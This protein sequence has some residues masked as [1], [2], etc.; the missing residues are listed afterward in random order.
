MH[1]PQDVFDDVG[2]ITRQETHP[3]TQPDTPFVAGVGIMAPPTATHWTP[4]FAMDIAMALELGPAGDVP[5]VLRQYGVSD[6]AY[7]QFTKDPVFTRQVEAFRSEVRDKGV[8]FRLKARVM[9]E[10]L[11]NTSWSMIHDRSVPPVVRADLI[12]QTVTWSGLAPKDAPADA[13][14]AGGVAITINLGGASQQVKVQPAVID[15]GVSDVGD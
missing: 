13:G 8:T 5:A 15:G 4:R 6:G 9:A 3:A 7:L 2:A 14:S 11:L 12:K 1:D 10:E